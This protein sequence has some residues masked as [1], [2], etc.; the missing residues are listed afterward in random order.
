MDVSP[1]S[2][3]EAQK[4]ADSIVDTPPQFTERAAALLGATAH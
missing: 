3:V 2:G 1:T 4:I